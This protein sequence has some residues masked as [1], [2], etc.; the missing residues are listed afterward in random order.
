MKGRNYIR[1]LGRGRFLEYIFSADYVK[2]LSTLMTLT[3]KN[4]DFLSR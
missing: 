1:K 4:N 3:L 2:K